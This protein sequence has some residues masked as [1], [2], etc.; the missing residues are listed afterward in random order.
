MICVSEV[1]FH[2][3][4][5]IVTNSVSPLNGIKPGAHTWFKIHGVTNVS[6]HRQRYDHP[7][8]A[9]QVRSRQN[10][11][12]SI[13]SRQDFLVLSAVGTAFCQK[14]METPPI[15]KSKLIR[16][17]EPLMPNDLLL[18]TFQKPTKKLQCLVNFF[19]RL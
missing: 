7:R 16:E 12:I 11:Q 4:S 15:L 8:Y 6:N 2:M 18:V 13:G 17:P 3:H 10:L 19:R 1:V 5:G 9:Q 14:N